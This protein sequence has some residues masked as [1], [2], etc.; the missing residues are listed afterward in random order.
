M[1]IE[2]TV[3]YIQLTMSICENVDRKKCIAIKTLSMYNVYQ[4]G[5]KNN[6]SQGNIFINGVK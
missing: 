1:I 5:N 4:Q 3:Q 6:T 2:E